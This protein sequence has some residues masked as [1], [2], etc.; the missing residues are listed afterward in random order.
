MQNCLSPYCEIYNDLIRTSKQIKIT[1]FL[2]RIED[3]KNLNE[4]KNS[5]SK[6]NIIQPKK[7]FRLIVLSSDKKEI[8]LKLH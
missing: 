7:H 2:K 5:E 3:T 8:T 4:E 6:G 1:D